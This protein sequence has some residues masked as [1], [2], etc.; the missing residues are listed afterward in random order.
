MK[1]CEKPQCIPPAGSEGPLAM[2]GNKWV[3]LKAFFYEFA[4]TIAEMGQ[5]PNYLGGWQST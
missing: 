2:C 3:V 1:K 5:V 4:L